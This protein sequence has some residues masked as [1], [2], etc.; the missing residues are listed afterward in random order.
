MYN[1]KF[2]FFALVFTLSINGQNSWQQNANYK[3]YIDVDVKKNTFKGSQEVLY[4]NNSPDT[5]NKVFFHLYF[6]AFRPESDMAERLNNGDDNNRRF[7]V[8]I[9]DLEPHEYGQLKVNNLKQD[10]L[11]IDSFVSDTILE[12]TLT[13]PILPGE[14]SLF[15]MNFNGQIPIT[16]RRAGRDSPMGVKYSMAQWYPKISEYD[17][18]GWNTAPYTGRE[19]HGV[20]GD[21]DVT[22]KIDKDFIV[23]ASGYIQETDPN[24]NKLGYLS[25][26]K[27]VWNFK[28]P[29]VHDFTWAAD[30]EYIHDIYPGPNGVKLNFYYKNDPKII[31][32]WKTLQ[33]V[34][35]ELMDFFNNYIGEYPYKQ[36]SVVQGGDGGMEY[37]MLTLLNYGE[38]LI[39]LISVTSHELA[40]AW[41]QGVLA[42]NEMNHAWM[43]EGSAS[44]FGELAESHVFNIDFHPIFTE[45][46]YQDYISLAT[47]GQEMPLATNANRFKFNRAYEDAAYDKGFVFLSQLNYI[48]GEKAFEKT[49]KNYFDKYKFTH[50]LPNDLRRVAEQSSGILLNWYLTD[51]TQT[52]NQI[53]YAIKNVESRKKKSVITLERI[54]LMPMPLEILVRYKDGNEEFYYI[55]ISLMRGEKSKPEYADKWIQLEDWSWAYKKYEFEIKSKMESIK[56]IDINPTG[57][58]ADVDT[59]NNIIKF[60]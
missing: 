1:Y 7:D 41:F 10:G 53:D 58:L 38:E 8:N 19:F 21:F 56:S 28:A 11:N 5:L 49:I 60:E 23:A 13:N 4:T 36:Y 57:L 29:K 14:S 51:W 26:K 35:A 20:W 15:T 43:D 55:P 40:H 54:G 3:I 2:L 24:N 18:E 31:A 33:P 16:I 42:T 25:G 52:T 37:S 59:S 34:T 46:P 32:N 30:S 44:Y 9:K 22:I 47:S 45:R 27:R 17:Y 50:P 39:P 6:N 12:V 48:I